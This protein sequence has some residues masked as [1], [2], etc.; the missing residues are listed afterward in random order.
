MR[1]PFITN[2]DKGGNEFASDILE[3]VSKNINTFELPK[4]SHRIKWAS[5][6]FDPIK[7]TDLSKRDGR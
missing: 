1:N 2:T 6:E 4:L 7:L 5:R 3:F